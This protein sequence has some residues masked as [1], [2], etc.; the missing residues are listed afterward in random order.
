MVTAIPVPGTTAAAGQQATYGLLVEKERCSGSRRTVEGYS[1][2]LPAPAPSRCAK[3]LRADCRTRPSAPGFGVSASDP[4]HSPPARAGVPAPPGACGRV[5]RVPLGPGSPHAECLQAFGQHFPPVRPQ[6]PH[7][8]LADG[9]RDHVLDGDAPSWQVCP[10]EVI[11]TYECSGL[12]ME[13]G[14]G[15]G[16]PRPRV[17][18]VR[19]NLT[20]PRI[21]E[22]VPIACGAHPP[23]TTRALVL[24]NPILV[25]DREGRPGIPT[26]PDGLAAC[27]CQSVWLGARTVAPCHSNGLVSDAGKSPLAGGRRRPGRRG[28][29]FARPPMGRATARGVGERPRP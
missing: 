20:C 10:C 23:G 28:L 15:D 5:L 13:M 2:T 22:G 4:T 17:P 6:R 12:E 1:R 21:R 29:G 14:P 19:K 7:A 27:E 16:H 25:G 18:V 8:H 26:Q 24:T 9:Q 3:A 11:P